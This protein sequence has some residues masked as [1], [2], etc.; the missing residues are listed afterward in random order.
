MALQYILKNTGNDLDRSSHK[1]VDEARSLD[2]LGLHINDGTFFYHKNFS[3]GDI[4]QRAHDV[5]GNHTVLFREGSALATIRSSFAIILSEDAGHINIITLPPAEHVPQFEAVREEF[6][7]HGPSF[8][9]PGSVGTL[10]AHLDNCESR[11]NG[12]GIEVRVKSI[13]SHFKQGKTFNNDDIQKWISWRLEALSA[14]MD[15]SSS[16][17]RDIIFDLTDP[18]LSRQFHRDDKPTSF[19]HRTVKLG[20]YFQMN[21]HIEGNILALRQSSL[22][23]TT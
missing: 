20:K 3:A 15:H 1:T 23:E 9:L 7:L 10:E 2:E 8:R 18:H 6:G 14:L 4:V 22:S 21:A 5:C 13:Q 17:T 16:H 11:K 12:A 19:F